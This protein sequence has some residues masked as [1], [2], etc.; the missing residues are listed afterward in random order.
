[1]SPPA[2]KVSGFRLGCGLVIGVFVGLV[3]L[4]VGCPMMMC[5]GLGAIGLAASE[6][7]AARREQEAAERRAEAERQAKQADWEASQSPPASRPSPKSNTAISLDSSRLERSPKQAIGVLSS[8]GESDRI[9][10]VESI[11]GVKVRWVGSVARVTKKTGNHFELIARCD[12]VR[13]RCRFE[14]KPPSKVMEL[15]QKARVAVYGVVVGYELDPNRGPSIILN[16]D[17]IN[18]VTRKP[19]SK[20]P[21]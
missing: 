20:N 13:V 12:G 4:V 8:A 5:G 9:A 1:M 6:A 7:D 19:K 2:A 18:G 21:R 14:G 16:A 10:L 17:R 11:Q 3:I 15:R